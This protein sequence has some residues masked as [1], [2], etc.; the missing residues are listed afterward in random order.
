M[1][2]RI[3]AEV[4]KLLREA[5]DRVKALLKKHEKALHALA[6]AL[7]ECETL[8]AED[9][10][11]ILLPYREGRLPEQQ[12]QPEVDEELALA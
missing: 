1:E 5:Y 10:K 7:L 8:N 11:R 3:D 2:S 9:I 12:T 6:N 4:V